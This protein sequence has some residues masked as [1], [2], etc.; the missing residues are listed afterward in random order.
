M[1]RFYADIAKRFDKFFDKET[2]QL[3][4]AVQVNVDGGKVN[5][6]VKTELDANDK[7]DSK[8]TVKHTCNRGTCQ[9]ETSVSKNPKFTFTTNQLPIVST[10]LS[11]QDP[12]VETEFSKQTDKVSHNVKAIYNWKNSGWEGEATVNYQGIDKMA[13]GGKLCVDRPSDK[14]IGIK[15]YNLKWEW[16]RNADQTLVVHTEEKLKIVNFGGFATLR[17]N[18]VGFGQV[19]VNWKTRD[20]FGWKAGF[21]KRIGDASTLTAIYRNGGCAST[22]YKTKINQFEGHV[23]YNCDCAKP[24]AE[25]HSLEYKLCF[26]Y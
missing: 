22:V 5:W 12:K 26:N 8:L 3:N 7:I 10:K 16:Q 18:L 9:L 17:E 13:L 14:S 1:A 19:G 4:R 2:Y 20:N 25:R 11:I 23:G 6:S 21:E 15:D 24:P